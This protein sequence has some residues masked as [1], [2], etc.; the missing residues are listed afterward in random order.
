MENLLNINE[1]HKVV[2][3][4][5]KMTNLINNKCYVGQTRSHRLNHNKYRPF[6]YMGRFK[7]HI[8]EAKNSTK[9]GCRYLNSALLK[10]GSEN[11][12]CE[13][14]MTC[15]LDE[16][17]S[18]E[19]KY[20]SEFNTKFPNGYN[21]TDGGKTASYKQGQK[22]II[23]DDSRIMKCDATKSP[24]PNLKR[25][26]YTKNLISA[27]L[28]EYKGDISH[29][30]ESMVTVQKQ[31]IIKKFD[32]FKN[33]HFDE[34]NIDQYIHV[35]RNNV[36]NYDFIGVNVGKVKTTFVGRFETIDEIKNRARNFIL[37]VIKQQHGQ[38]AGNPLE[39]S[40]PL[41]TRKDVEEHD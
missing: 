18:Y 36:L 11:F 17:D 30:K 7:D 28:K 1:F 27:R 12:T 22:R 6:G 3:E 15:S 38:I 2:G 10:N 41:C 13:L 21:L 31:H 20:I 26:E 23:L 19:V 39:P 40:L 32:Q 5:Y 34:D 37:D 16:L 8:S 33:V 29:R 35:L 4:I 9:T 14:I 24:N 25:S